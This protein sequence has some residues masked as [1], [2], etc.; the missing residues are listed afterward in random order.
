[1]RGGEVTERGVRGGS[2]SGRGKG[3]S[4]C[5]G[6]EEGSLVTLRMVT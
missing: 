6:N 5:L 4:G 3:L 2:L 1:V